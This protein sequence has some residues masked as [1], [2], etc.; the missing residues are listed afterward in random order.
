MATSNTYSDCGQGKSGSADR[1]S[2]WPW[3]RSNITKVQYQK[4]ACWMAAPKLPLLE[5]WNLSFEDVTQLSLFFNCI[6]ASLD[7]L[8]RR[9]AESLHSSCNSGSSTAS[10][11][12]SWAF[13]REAGW[14]TWSYHLETIAG[15]ETWTWIT[16]PFLEHEQFAFDPFDPF[17]GMCAGKT[18]GE[19]M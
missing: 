10:P 13:W 7:M 17:R 5:G 16:C 11:I 8:G 14:I 2:V 19:P 1:H 15:P 6:L 3:R 9:L 12:I 18:S 4:K